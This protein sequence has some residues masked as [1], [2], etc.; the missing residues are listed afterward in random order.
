M[1]YN[2]ILR[3]LYVDFRGKLFKRKILKNT[4][5]KERFKSRL[6]FMIASSTI[7]S[8]ENMN[9]CK[10]IFCSDIY[11]LCGSFNRFLDSL[12]LVQ[13]YL[14]LEKNA[15]VLSPTDRCYY[16]NNPVFP[17][18][19]CGKLYE[20]KQTSK[21]FQD[22]EAEFNKKIDKNHFR[23]IAMADTV[24]IVDIDIVDWS[25][26][27]K[28]YVGKDTT[29]EIHFALSLSKNVVFLSY[30]MKLFKEHPEL[31]E[32]KNNQSDIG[33]D[34]LM[35]DIFNFRRKMTEEIYDNHPW[36]D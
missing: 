19:T 5:V 15:L 36:F 34:N 33:K 31:A 24:L 11:C 26:D 7:P 29:Q 9:D 14:T 8:I 25:S 32:G 30:L 13:D 17:I 6:N 18:Y 28:D 22:K 10:D 2:N 21:I 12:I 4:S 16:P 27:N 23:K 1:K 35:R 3:S 20:N